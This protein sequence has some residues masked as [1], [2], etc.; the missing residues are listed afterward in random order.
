MQTFRRGGKICGILLVFRYFRITI[1]KYCIIWAGAQTIE[2]FGRHSMRL[3]CF[4]CLTNAV[5]SQ[6]IACVYIMHYAS[7]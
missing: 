1:P 2:D 7:Q 6:W 3:M 4:V 5:L